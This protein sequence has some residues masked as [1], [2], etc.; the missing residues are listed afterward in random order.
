MEESLR[1]QVVSGLIPFVVNVALYSRQLEY[2]ARSAS[3]Q[4]EE[5]FEAFFGAVRYIDRDLKGSKLGFI[6]VRPLRLDSELSPHARIDG[7]VTVTEEARHSML[8]NML[9]S[10]VPEA[11][12]SPAVSSGRIQVKPHGAQF[13]NLDQTIDRMGIHERKSPGEFIVEGRE[14]AVLKG[15]L[16]PKIN[17]QVSDVGPL[18]PLE[19]FH[20][21]LQIELDCFVLHFS[22]L[23]LREVGLHFVQNSEKRVNGWEV[24]LALFGFSFLLPFIQCIQKLELSILRGVLSH[25]EGSEFEDELL[26]LDKHLL[27]LSEC[28]R[29]DQLSHDGFGNGV[30]AL[31]LAV[32]PVDNLLG[33]ELRL[34]EVHGGGVFLVLL[35]RLVL[36]GGEGAH[37]TRVFFQIL[38][39]YS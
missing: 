29:A 6:R 17:Q 7:V 18:F 34:L 38:V 27:G 11:R 26:F 21:F 8:E 33:E 39:H 24:L 32:M 23:H 15:T 13:V 22:L 5:E 37:L 31:V 19:T 1:E 20:H 3:L 16:I 9:I 10:T 4:R 30:T 36:E 25:S 12:I 14:G 28:V 35:D 2:L